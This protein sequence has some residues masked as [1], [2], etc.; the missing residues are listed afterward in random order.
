[1]LSPPKRKSH[2]AAFAKPCIRGTGGSSNLCTRCWRP[3][4]HISGSEFPLP[5]KFRVKRDVYHT[6]SYFASQTLGRGVTENPA[7]QRLNTRREANRSI[8]CSSLGPAKVLPTAA[9]HSGPSS[10]LHQATDGLR[11]MTTLL[12]PNASRPWFI[13]ARRACAVAKKN[14]LSAEATHR[15]PTG[16]GD[17]RRI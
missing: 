11:T 12:Y 8:H 17:S 9:G 6:N 7:Q 4:I 15:W 2:R 16:Q 1:M 13:P 14:F 3:K 10:G 5:V